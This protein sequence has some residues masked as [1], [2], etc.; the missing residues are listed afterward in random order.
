LAIKTLVSVECMLPDPFS[1]AVECIIFDVSSSFVYRF[2]VF[3]RPNTEPT[4]ELKTAYMNTMLQCMRHFCTNDIVPIIFGDFNCDA[5]DWTIGLTN[6][7][8]QKLF[9]DCTVELGLQQHVLALTR[10]N[11]ILDLLFTNDPAVLFSCIVT[12][13]FPGSD[14]LSLNFTLNFVCD[15]SPPLLIP[16]LS[17]VWSK[18][19]WGSMFN[20]FCN[21][22]WSA[23]FN[24]YSDSNS[25]WTAFHTV[26]LFAVSL[27][28]PVKKLSVSSCRLAPRYAKHILKVASK[29]LTIWNRL[30]A[31]RTN[32]ILHN[33]YSELTVLY[34]KLTF[35]H[36][37]KAEHDILANNNLGGFF[38]YIN[39]KSVCRSGVPVLKLCS[40]SDFD[41]A[42]LLNET[43]TVT[44]LWTMV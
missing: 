35:Q 24:A 40:T 22:D 26:I 30:K 29:K 38:H 21:I 27:F 20:Y 3:Y 34:K 31:D 23:L 36:E 5:V 37:S 17:D 15:H 33:T 28:V 32:P 10:G 8:I 2:F 18:A 7:P 19:D 4:A 25:L 11:N 9:L 6:N 41:K 14:H 1:Y 16:K 13:G 44:M 39:S 43:F 42:Q 12:E